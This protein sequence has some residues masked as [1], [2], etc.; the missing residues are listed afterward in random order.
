MGT[1]CF[2]QRREVVK[3]SLV[4]CWTDVDLRAPV[5]AV[6]AV[7]ATLVDGKEHARRSEAVI[8]TVTSARG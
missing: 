7:E 5:E 8:A 2:R 3:V 4:C 1:D 6:E